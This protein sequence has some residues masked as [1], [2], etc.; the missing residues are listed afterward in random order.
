MKFKYGLPG[1]V[2]MSSS[3]IANLEKLQKEWVNQGVSPIIVSLIARRGV[4]VSHNFYVN[5]E[6]ERNYGPVDL[7]TIFPL[8][9]I[10][11]S[12]T[13]SAIMLLVE[14]GK[15]A[16]NVPV[17]DYIPEFVGEHKEK[18]LIHH[19]MTHTSGIAEDY[20]WNAMNKGEAPSDRSQCPNNQHPEVF[21]YLTA[22]YEA[23]LSF[24]PGKEMRYCGFAFTLLTEVIRRV[25][26]QSFPDFVEE[27]LFNPLG[28]VD[29]HFLLPESKYSRVA[30]HPPN[31]PFPDFAHYD[32]ISIPW[33]GSGLCSTV[34]DM[35]VFAQTFLNGG[36]YNDQRLWSKLSVEK[37][38]SNQIPGVS[39]RI[40]DEFFREACWG[41]AWN[42]SGSKQD[43][44][45]TLRSEKTFSNSGRGNTLIMVDPVNEMVILNFQITMKRVNNRPYHYFEYFSDAALSCMED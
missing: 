5:P 42:V 21:K 17:Q 26:G 28:M 12:V 39:S 35:A 1:E 13:A 32:Q 29:S 9:S 23:P 22:G 6:Y 30:Q 38:T 44:T 2:G 3:R 15:V 36:S 43:Y 20:I 19:L 10:S 18:V 33:G 14:E 37:M 11:K 27:R 24:L 7:N 34:M 25:T 40:G 8:A 41:L 4:I 16:V 45:G 31:A